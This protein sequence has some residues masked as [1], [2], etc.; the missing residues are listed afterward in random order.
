MLFFVKNQTVFFMA[1]L[2]FGSSLI[3]FSA[4]VLMLR[5]AKVE[6]ALKINCALVLVGPTIFFLVTLLGLG[7]LVD[8]MPLKKIL[9]L[10]LGLSLIFYSFKI[11]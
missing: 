8:K 9:C 1:L 6:T 5:L 3:E 10:L 4:A 11:K 2:R 7:D